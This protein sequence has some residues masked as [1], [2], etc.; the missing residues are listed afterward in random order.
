MA[1]EDLEYD[2]RLDDLAHRCRIP[3]GM[4]LGELPEDLPERV[5]YRFSFDVCVLP[6][7]VQVVHVR[8]NP[9]PP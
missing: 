5:W 2:P 1:A 9:I 7:G 8:I 3:I 4:I 6:S